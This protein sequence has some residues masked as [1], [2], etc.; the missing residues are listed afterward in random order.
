MTFH[1]KGKSFV[2]ASVQGVF[3]A[4][5]FYINCERSFKKLKFL[6]KEAQSRGRSDVAQR[7]VS[8]ISAIV[9]ITSYE[10]V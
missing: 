6:I 9:R 4:I 5:E 3:N 10:Q 8:K 2:K 7:Y 1:N